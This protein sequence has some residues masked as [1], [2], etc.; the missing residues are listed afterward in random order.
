MDDGSGTANGTRFGIT[1]AAHHGDECTT[2]LGVLRA[3]PRR[4]VAGARRYDHG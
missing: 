1:E 3:G 2:V 4:R